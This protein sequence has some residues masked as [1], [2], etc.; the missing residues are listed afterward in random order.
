MDH[1]MTWLESMTGL[2]R[3]DRQKLENYRNKLSEQEK[4]ELMKLQTDLYLL[5]K[6]SQFAPDH[7]AEYS[8]G[9]LLLATKKMQS[10]DPTLRSNRHLAAMT[11]E[12]RALHYKRQ[13][14]RVRE[15]T[16]A[17]AAPKKAWILR[18]YD[19]LEEMR[20]AGFSWRQLA[21]AVRSRRDWRFEK[22]NDV[23]LREVMSDERKRRDL[24]KKLI[25]EAKKDG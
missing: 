13:L 6:K 10:L 3:A 22:L 15:A 17:K 5:H 25:E 21:A 16:M 7:K 20:Q 4:I 19:D 9:C 8:Y 1:D 18:N 24:Q 14:E 12:E 11:P 2:T 23:Y